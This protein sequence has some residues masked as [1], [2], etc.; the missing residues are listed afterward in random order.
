MTSKH[1][2]RKDEHVSLAEKFHHPSTTFAQVRIIH[3]SLPE[4]S[5]SQIET[6][7][8]FAGKKLAF[9]VFIEAMTGGSPKT[10]QFNAQLA[11]L[12]AHFHLAMAVGSQSVAFSEPQQAKTFAIVRDE[13]PDG[14]VIANLGA[15]H[16]LQD[17]QT[18]I[19]MVAA[20]AIQLHVNATQELIMPEGD[21]EFYWRQN[22]AQLVTKLDIP[23]IVKEVGFGMAK[24]TV[25]DLAKLGVQYVD[26]SG[27]GGTNFAMIENFR[28]SGKELDYL[29]DWGQ[30]TAESL[31]ELG[32]V[33][34]APTAFVSGGIQTPLD[35]IKSLAMGAEYVGMAGELLHQLIS[36]DYETTEAWLATWLA[37]FK[38]LLLLTGSSKLA[39]LNRLHLVYTNELLDYKHERN[40]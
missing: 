16:S 33:P 24:E 34:D 4:L 6:T 17:C 9:P 7:T 5:L 22:I 1:V 38:K 31:L 37:D 12:A 39:D 20:D 23:V 14:V 21:T 18:A 8:T 10:G 2:H 36:T 27:R 40:L 19:N 28:R 13:N 35:A 29:T 32:A 30:T 15:D 11:K 26:V 3:Q 25:V